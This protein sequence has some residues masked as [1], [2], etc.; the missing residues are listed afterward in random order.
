MQSSCQVNKILLPTVK[1]DTQGLAL[2]SRRVQEVDMSENYQEAEFS[3]K[4][5]ET[6][7]KYILP[8]WS[9]NSDPQEQ[10]ESASCTADGRL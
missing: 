2:F 1:A 5:D 6:E 7:S 9:N 4:T 10:L 3:S 8:G